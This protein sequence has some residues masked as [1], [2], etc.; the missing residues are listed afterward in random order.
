MSYA[1]EMIGT[2]SGQVV[3]CVYGLYLLALLYLVKGKGR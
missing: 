1:A 3:A 2:C